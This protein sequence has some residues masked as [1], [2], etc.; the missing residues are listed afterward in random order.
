DRVEP[1]GAKHPRPGKALGTLADA[2][3]SRSQIRDHEPRLAFPSG[4]PANAYDVVEDFPDR[5]WV[6][7]EYARR[8][9]HRADDIV[10]GPAWNGADLAQALGQDEIGLE[11]GEERRIQAV[12]SVGIALTR[13]D[14]GVDLGAAETGRQQTLR[15]DRLRA[16]SFGVI[17]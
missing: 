17:T 9:W 6:A 3:D 8:P 16:R 14:G 4:R 5:G 1:F 2:F 7:R 10:D 11:T 15:Q 13:G 12:E